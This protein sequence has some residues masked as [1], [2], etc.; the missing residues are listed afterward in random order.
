MTAHTDYIEETLELNE[1]LRKIMPFVLRVLDIPEPENTTARIAPADLHLDSPNAKGWARIPTNTV[2]VL[3]EVV[4]NGGDFNLVNVIIHE[5][6]HLLSA[7]LPG[8][9]VRQP[10]AGVFQELA[11]QLGI[12][13]RQGN[14][15]AMGIRYKSPMWKFL[16]EHGI[17]IPERIELLPT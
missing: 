6:I 4:A 10:H 3:D 16:V 13:T 7:D 5:I 14:G 15:E 2:Y 11:S 1:W 12:T 9:D 17:R 8:Y